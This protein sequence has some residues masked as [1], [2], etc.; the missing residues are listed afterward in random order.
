[1]FFALSLLFAFVILYFMIYN[2][3]DSKTISFKNMKEE[4]KVE[5]EA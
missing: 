3:S 1:M 4:T 5:N 2:E